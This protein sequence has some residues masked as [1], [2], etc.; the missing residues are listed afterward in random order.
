MIKTKIY[1]LYCNENITNDELK[2]RH[3]CK[4]EIIKWNIPQSNTHDH[5][6]KL[7]KKNGKL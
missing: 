6:N 4:G 7:D 2:L 1:C 3:Y 5:I